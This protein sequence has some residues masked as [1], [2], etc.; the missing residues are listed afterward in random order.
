M[1][2]V[3][4][5][6]E[7]TLLPFLS[8]PFPFARLRFSSRYEIAKVKFNYRR[9]YYYQAIFR[10]M[11]NCVMAGINRTVRSIKEFMLTG[12]FLSVEE[13]VYGM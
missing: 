8:F 7:I 4:V 11:P 13:G 5:R 6:T 2:A 3:T 9:C 10:R 12:R 1:T